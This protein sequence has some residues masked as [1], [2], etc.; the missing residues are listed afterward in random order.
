MTLEKVSNA[1]MTYIYGPLFIPITAIDPSIGAAEAS[2]TLAVDNEVK[3]VAEET[4]S[5]DFTILR[6]L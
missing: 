4:M 3:T 5:E 1:E 6:M 2:C